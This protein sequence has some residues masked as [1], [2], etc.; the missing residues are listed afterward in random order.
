MGNHREIRQVQPLFQ[1]GVAIPVR[2]GFEANLQV[3]LNKYK[4]GHFYSYFASAGEDCT[5]RNMDL[6]DT[7]VG[8]S[9]RARFIVQSGGKMWCGYQAFCEHIAEVAPFIE[10][11]LFFIGDEEDYIDRFELAN[12]TLQYSR[13][14]SGGWRSVEDYIL[15]QFPELRCQSD[16]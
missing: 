2:V 8:I 5:I 3:V 12:R 10:D 6:D 13:V 4:C 1:I 11:A 15:E 14:H 9:R 7:W 16:R